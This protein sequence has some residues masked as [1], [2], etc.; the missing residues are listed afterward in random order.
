MT[1]KDFVLGEMER[2]TTGVML[3]ASGIALYLHGTTINQQGVVKLG[4]GLCS[5]GLYA[6][7]SAPNQ[8]PP[9][10]P[11]TTTKTET[12]TVPPPEIPPV[13]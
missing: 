6:L 12:V 7:R 11:N 10:P 4:E 1:V 13:P 3:L 2:N 9:A 5:A 8:P